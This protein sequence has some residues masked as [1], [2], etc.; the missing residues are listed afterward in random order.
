MRTARFLTAAALA[1]LCLLRAQSQSKLGDNSAGSRGQPAHIIPLRDPEGDTIQP[2]DRHSLPFS[3]SQTCGGECHDVANISDGWHFNAVESYGDP[4]RNGQPWILVDAQTGTQLPLS[5]RTWPGTYRPRD[6]GVDVH[7]FAVRFG[8]RTAGGFSPERTERRYHVYPDE[9]SH[10]MAWRISG[11]LEVNCLV[12]HDASPAYDQAEYANQVAKENFRYAPAA[13]SGLGLVTGSSKQMP[14]T[15]DY[16]LPNSVEDSLQPQIPKVEY[17]PT[18]FLPSGKVAFD[19]VRSAKSSQCYYCHTNVD[20]QFTGADRFKGHEDIHLARGIGCNEC[21]RHGLDHMVTRGYEPGALSCEGCHAEGNAM[22]APHPGHEGIPPV[23]FVKMT[24]TACHSGPLP[25]RTTRQFKNGM[26]HG[27]GE[28]NVNKSPDAL[29]HLYYPVFARNQDGKLAPN[30][31]VWPAFWGRLQNGA[32]TPLHPDTV[33]KAI[34][35]AKLA[36]NATIDEHWVEAVLRVL[37][38]DGPSA[39]IAGG[40][41][42]RLSGGKLVAEDNKQ[43]EPYLW[44]IGHDVRPA[45]QALGAK[46]CQ[47]CHSTDGAI[48][49]GKVAVDSPIASERNAMWTMSRFETNLDVNYQARLAGTWRYRGLLKGIGLAAAGVLLLVLL[50]YTVRAVE[51]LSAAFAGRTR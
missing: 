17:A 42:H 51:R 43:A 21:H 41:L 34:A 38:T 25:E 18:D 31:M 37:D 2:G 46:G 7:E 39:Y 15:F 23:H 14:D 12:C 26:T 35:K 13:A 36:A 49:F 8:G 50:A 3:V 45:T 32:V 40:K 16:L 48:F 47:D 19:I 6:A 9:I 44:P 10:A 30:R 33:K 27:L 11:N 28:F 24:C 20:T 22:G 29:P 5:Y 4:G 1:T